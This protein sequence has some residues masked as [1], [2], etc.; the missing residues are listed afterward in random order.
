MSELL[1]IKPY[2]ERKP[3]ALSGGQRQRVAMGRAIVRD[4]AVFLFDEPLSNLD[5]KLRSEMRYEIKKLHQKLKTTCIYVTHDQTEATTLADRIVILNQGKIEQVGTPQ[6]LYQNPQT[7]F[8]GGFI[9]HYPMNF[10]PGLIHPQTKQIQLIC[11]SSVPKPSEI[12]DNVPDQILVGIRP[13]HISIFDSKDRN[14]L[15]AS[16]EFMD[17]MGSDKLIRLKTLQ[18]DIPI[19]VRYTDA[20]IQRDNIALK[21]HWK[22]ASIFC[23]HSRKRIGGW[24]E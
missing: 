6:T 3:K 4:P 10:I 16:F 7:S 20:W 2:L 8:V 5:T 19:D 17:D 1:Q 23:K 24:G 12:R 11:G 9:G 21:I 15:M 14:E 18:G 13:E 22:N